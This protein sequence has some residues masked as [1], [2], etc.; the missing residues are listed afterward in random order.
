M[1]LKRAF[2]VGM[3]ALAMTAGGAAVPGVAQDCGWTL[4]GTTGPAPRNGHGLVYDSGHARTVLFGG[5]SGTRLGDTWEWDGNTW[6]QRAVTGPSARNADA[7]AYDAGR[8]RIERL[9]GVDGVGVLSEDPVFVQ[10]RTQAFPPVHVSIVMH[11]EEPP[12]YPDFVNDESAFWQHRAALVQFVHM[13]QFNGVMFNY[14]SD[15]NF[16]QAVAA[17]DTGTPDTNGKNVVRHIKEDLGFEVDPH[18]HESVYN[19]A[20]VAYLIQALGVAPSHTVGGYLADPPEQSK[21]EYFWQPI[22]GR[23]YSTYVWQAE[24]LFGGATLFH[25]NEEPLWASGIWKPKDKYHYLE[26]DA[27]A[28]LPNVGNYGSKWEHL[29]RL[30][31]MQQ[32]GEL[33]E[34]KIYTGLIFVAQDSLLL[35][36]FVQDF[37]QRIHDRDAAGNIHWIGVA[38]AIETWQTEYD[39]QP[40]IL[41]YLTPDSTYTTE[42]IETWLPAPNGNLLYARIVQP[43]PA[44]YPGQRFPALIAIPGGIGPGAPLADNPGY[45]GLAAEGF[46]VVVFNAEGRG[47]GQPGNL[48]SQ[49][50]EN[51]NGFIHQ[52][53]LKAVIDYA[54]ARPNVV[55]DNI[56]VMTS[57]YGITMGAGCLGRYATLPVKYLIDNEGPSDNY[58]TSFEPWA[59]DSDPNNDRHQSAYQMFGHWS[60]LRDPSAA[61]QAWWSQREATRFI[62]QVRCRYLRVQAE[63]DHAQPPNVQWPGFDYYPLWYPGK[64]TVDMVNLATQGRAAWTRVNAA[65]IGNP[66]NQTYDHD[67]PP[68]FYGQSMSTHPDEPPRIVRE[69]AAMPALVR[70][71]DLNCDG[72]VSFA[73]IDPFVAALGGESAYAAAFPGCRWLNA[74]CNGDGQVNFAD[75]DAFVALL[76]GR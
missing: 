7:L 32:N 46:V 74:D 60:V 37:E 9:G 39:S 8:N 19:Y 17:Y 38:Q 49:G 57:S 12:Q 51:C 10:E 62:G 27:G 76:G 2:R 58:V 42:T 73:D 47:T 75:I 15:W 45:R 36:G 14:Q 30:L 26:H 1:I 24:I 72:V 5:D 31:L 29:D 61:N 28:P 65:S 11:N 34:G 13:L 3:A 41:R 59:L 64:H 18:A 25:V 43:V 35:P 69:Q 20:D 21:L 23:Q 63:W 53:D 44:L 48:R 68:V 33:E 66:P 6:T 16:L 67:H 54:H 50:T 4:R 70:L 22:T 40:N 52:D 55:G 71:G 56:G